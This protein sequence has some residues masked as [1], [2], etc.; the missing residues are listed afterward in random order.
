MTADSLFPA[1]EL[2]GTQLQEPPAASVC[3]AAETA[4]AAA[5]SPAT[6][7]NNADMTLSTKIT[8]TT[9]RSAC[10]RAIGDIDYLTTDDFVDI[11][12]KL[13]VQRPRLVNLHLDFSRLTFL[14]SAA[15][16]GLLL[17]HRRCSQSGV[18]LHLDNRPAFLDRVLHITGLYSHFVPSDAEDFAVETEDSRRFDHAT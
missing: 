4:L 11:A 6:D 9:A 17:I 12:S 1:L 5:N 16:S 14:D 10:L 3:C 15:L 18:Q 2:L 7:P 8:T 13:L